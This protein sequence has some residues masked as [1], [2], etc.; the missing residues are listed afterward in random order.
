MFFCFPTLVWLSDLK[1]TAYTIS[2][3][4]GSIEGSRS[5]DAIMIFKEL[6]KSFSG[7]VD[8][9]LIKINDHV[10]FWMPC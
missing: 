8:V 3:G 10:C 6:H 4:G 2:L 1:H 9:Q 7:K 5:G